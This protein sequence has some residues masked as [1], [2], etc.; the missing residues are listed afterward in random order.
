MEVQQACLDSSRATLKKLLAK[1]RKGKAVSED[2]TPEGR[3]QDAALEYL[4][5]LDPKKATRV[6]TLVKRLQSKGYDVNRNQVNTGL[7]R[8]MKDKLVTKAN[9]KD[10]D[11]KPRQGFWKAVQTRPKPTTT[12]KKRSRARRKR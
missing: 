9:V 7:Y 5:A 1:V 12:T 4:R 6:P 3:W 10:K 2:E 8:M 11:G